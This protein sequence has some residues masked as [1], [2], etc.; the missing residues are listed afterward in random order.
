MRLAMKQVLDNALKYSPPGLP[1]D[2]GIIGTEQAGIIEVT[3][4]G[5]GIPAEELPRIF[6]RFY[7]SPAVQKK[8][9]GSGLGLSIAHRILRAH[10]GDLTVTSKPGNTTFRM[11]LPIA[12]K[13]IA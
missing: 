7:R 6:E 8:I 11:V 13:E 2:I 9:P 1:V 12:G 5:T 10:N 3:D 4:H